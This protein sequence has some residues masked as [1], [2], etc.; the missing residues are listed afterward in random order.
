M[1]DLKFRIELN[2]LNHLGIGLYSSTPAVVTEIIS[3]AWD[4]DASKVT[5]DLKSQ[6]DSILVRTMVTE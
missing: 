4:A 5:I 2:V 3:N 1:N 6:E